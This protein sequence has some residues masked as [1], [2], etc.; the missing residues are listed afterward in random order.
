LG[1]TDHGEAT[2]TA[3][4]QNLAHHRGRGG[5]PVRY[6]RA[7]RGGGGHAAFDVACE[8]RERATE[9]RCRRS[10][11]PR[12]ANRGNW[13]RHH[14]NRCEA[15]FRSL[16]IRAKVGCRCRVAQMKRA[17]RA[18]KQEPHLPPSRFFRVG[19]VE[20]SFV[21]RGWPP[22]GREKFI[23]K[24]RDVGIVNRRRVQPSRFL[25]RRSAA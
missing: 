25:R 8:M 20:S 2:R 1:D 24:R 10:K 3:A 6:R 12:P 19:H 23:A 17:A 14:L 7:C 15:E 11:G 9:S 21:G 5:G 22:C 18:A 16:T 13:L 4:F